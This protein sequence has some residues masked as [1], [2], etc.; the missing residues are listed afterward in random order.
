MQSANM[1]LSLVSEAD[2]LTPEESGAGL[3][4]WL[5]D[6]THSSVLYL[7]H[8]NE[9]V[10]PKEDSGQQ[11][12]KILCTLPEAFTHGIQRVIH[13]LTHSLTHSFVC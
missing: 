4:H 3:G 10:L 6:E 9:A 1:E 13:S 2:S 8:N 7:M 5:R 12:L 11:Y